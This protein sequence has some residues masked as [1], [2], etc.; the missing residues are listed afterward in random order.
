M[1]LKNSDLIKQFAM[2]VIAAIIGGALVLFFLKKDSDEI[3]PEV[4]VE[5]EEVQVLSDTQQCDAL[6]A[7]PDDPRKTVAG[8]V[9]LDEFTHGQRSPHEALQACESALNTASEQDKPRINY[10]LYRLSRYLERHG[11]AD[12]YLGTAQRAEYPAADY[13]VA[14]MFY[15]R[16]KLNGN[17]EYD[18]VIGTLEFAAQRGHPKAAQEIKRLYEEEFPLN[19]YHLPGLMRAIY[20]GNQ[21]AIPDD[22]FTRSVNLAIYQHLKDYCKQFE[23]SVVNILTDAEVN[24]YALPLQV[25]SMVNGVVG[26]FDFLNKAGKSVDNFNRSADLGSLIRDINSANAD[27]ENS[28]AYLHTL[29]LRDAGLFVKNHSCAGPQANKFINNL[30]VIFQ[31]RQ[32]KNPTT[33]SQDRIEAL[34]KKPVF[35][36]PKPA[37]KA[38]PQISAPNS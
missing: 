26:F 22:R 19:G 16:G 18:G 2:M 14:M 38:P 7:D 20:D 13:A 11:Q 29:G 3:E 8:G 6:A 33:T 4:G 25:N 21:N 9:Y 35:A 34:Y 24:N 5:A 12:G 37:S 30:G 23:A 10:Q 27:W 36:A 1:P 28:M 17:I 31:A 32:G 15:E